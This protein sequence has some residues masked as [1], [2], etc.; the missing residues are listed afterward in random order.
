MTNEITPTHSVNIDDFQRVDTVSAG[1]VSRP[2]WNPAEGAAREAA[3]N[4]ARAQ[5]MEEHLKAQ[6]E[7]ANH[8]TTERFLLMEGAIADLQKKVEALTDAKK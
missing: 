8:F 5:A 7:R 1:S 6:A 2:M 3:I 4:E